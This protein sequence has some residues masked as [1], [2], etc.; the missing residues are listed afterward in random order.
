ML[1]IFPLFLLLL[2]PSWS[3][4]A[5]EVESKLLQVIDYNMEP[6]EYE[7]GGITVSGGNISRKMSGSIYRTG[8][9]QRS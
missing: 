2:L 1:K 9:W 3:L 8:G 4:T 7:I 5:Q 6:R